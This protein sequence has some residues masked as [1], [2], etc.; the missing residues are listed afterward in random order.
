MVSDMAE[1]VQ[2]RKFRLYPNGVVFQSPTAFRDIYN[3]RANVKRSKTY[4]VWQKNENDIN[5]LSTSDSA[6][7]YKKRRILNTVFTETSIRAAGLFIYKHVDRWNELLLD[8]DG[9]DWSQPK[10]LAEH[11]DNLVFDILG[12]LC[13][14]KSFETKEAGENPFRNI[15]A[16]IHSYMRFTYPVWSGPRTLCGW[17]Y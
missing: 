17:S 9:K 7:H 15:P 5:T 13:F 1:I 14:G 2:G 16:A 11:V 10:N 12:D 6:I 3:A 8:G 4:D